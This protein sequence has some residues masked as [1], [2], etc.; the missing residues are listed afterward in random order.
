MDRAQPG[1]KL[2][3][4]T[5]LST[6]AK[7]R[8]P[9]ET[10]K[11]LEWMY[12]LLRL[13]WVESS[14]MKDIQN[15]INT[16]QENFGIIDNICLESYLASDIESWLKDEQLDVEMV[17]PN[18]KNQYVA[19]TA[20]WQL[21]ENGL[22]KAPPLP[23]FRIRGTSDIT[24]IGEEPDLF[25]EEL[26]VFDHDPDERIF[27]SPYKKKKKEA[28]IDTW[29]LEKIYD[30]SVYSVAWGI[31]ASRDIWSGSLRTGTQGFFGVRVPGSE[32]LYK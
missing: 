8:I 14:E 23:Y 7:G 9:W 27:G 29:G 25:R 4:R 20:L 19:F 2:A 17:F 16:V 13:V 21:M 18:Y 26:E 22:F 28:D 10:D 30:D 24:V 32:S 11:R 5:F 6:I 12:F 3:N 1:S 31:Y 15:E